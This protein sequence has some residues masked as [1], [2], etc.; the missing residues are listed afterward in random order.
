MLVWITDLFFPN[1][2]MFSCTSYTHPSVGA[3]LTFCRLSRLMYSTYCGWSFPCCGCLAVFPRQKERYRTTLISILI[4]RLFGGVNCLMKRAYDYSWAYSLAL[5]T[6]LSVFFF[7]SLNNT[8]LGYF[9]PHNFFCLWVDVELEKPWEKC[10]SKMNVW[11]SWGSAIRFSRPTGGWRRSRSKVPQGFLVV[12]VDLKIVD[13]VI[14]VWHCT[15]LAAEGSRQEKRSN[16]INNLFCQ[17]MQIK[18]G[19]AQRPK[20]MASHWAHCP[21]I[22]SSDL[23]VVFSAFSILRCLVLGGWVHGG[24]EWYCNQCCD[25]LFETTIVA[26]IC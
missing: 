24:R 9:V 25:L 2:K 22:S 19:R 15:F 6:F 14:R 8:R 11:P 7:V 10:K 26:K 13:L 1:V 17:P 20:G 5:F 12:V 18:T 16:A 21:F 4:F 3:V 23:L